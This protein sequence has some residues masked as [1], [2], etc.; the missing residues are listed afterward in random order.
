[1]AFCARHASGLLA[2][3]GRPVGGLAGARAAAP[4]TSAPR[5]GPRRL[6]VCC[7]ASEGGGEKK[8]GFGLSLGPIGLTLGGDLGEAADG[9][10][11]QVGTQEKEGNSVQSA[12]SA[13]GVSLGPIGLTLGGDLGE[14]ADGQVKTN[15]EA[16]TEG[17]ESISSMT[18]E[19]WR[20][21]Y[22]PH[23][24]VSLW[25]EE[26]FN[27]GSRLIGGR[28]VHKGGWAGRDSGEGRSSRAED[29]ET[30]T[31]KIYSHLQDKEF[32][33]QVPE[34]RYILWEAED[35]GLELPHACRMGCCTACAVKVTEGEVEQYQALGVS[36]ELREKGYA[37]MC[38]AYPLT[39]C[40]ME[41]VPEDEVYELQ[42]GKAF[43]KQATDPS[44]ATIERDDFA[45][46]I[47]NMDE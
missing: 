27:S 5:S 38:V 23:G 21:K 45:I 42:F 2:G 32:E 34:D 18:T 41:T 13:S 36:R 20:A 17:L 39:D 43:A 12:A 37:L 15:L 35:Q 9:K 44:A 16:N 3:A 30:L 4:S 8:K 11:G 6:S 25:V 28:T 7:K 26:E 33:V 24:R 22:E 40:R 47:A 46:E 31:V 29:E 14:E 19:E 10:T 1:M